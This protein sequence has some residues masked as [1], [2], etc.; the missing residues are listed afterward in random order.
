[1]KNLLSFL[2]FISSLAVNAQQI[3]LDTFFEKGSIWCET[4]KEFGPQGFI[5]EHYFSFKI[6]KDT[7]INNTIYQLL[8]CNYTYFF[9]VNRNTDRYEIVRNRYLAGIRHDSGKVFTIL[10]DTLPYPRDTSIPIMVELPL[11]DFSIDQD[12]IVNWKTG[13]KKVLRTDSL[14]LSNGNYLRE[15]V[16]DDTT[17]AGQKVSEFWAYGIGSNKGFFDPLCKKYLQF[18]STITQDQTF[19]MAAFH[20]NKSGYYAFQNVDKGGCYPLEIR[21]I[22]Y[23]YSG[24]NLYP[25]PMV[26]SEL[27]L[28]SEQPVKRIIITDI[29]GRIVSQYH[30]DGILNKYNNKLNLQLTVG[31]YFATVFFEDGSTYKT[32]LVKL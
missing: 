16:F 6:D 7:I 18:Q 1:M 8:L 31:I 9:T 5:Y 27:N 14:Q 21:D 25:N 22:K 10:L 4:R 11:Y 2:I 26:N 19:H 29:S 12:S 30:I 15:Y 32:K 23:A 20:Q 28:T 3:P 13:K 17:I 24:I